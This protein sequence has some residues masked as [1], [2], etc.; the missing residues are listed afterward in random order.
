MEILIN[1]IQNRKKII[2][3]VLIVI[4]IIILFAMQFFSKNNIDK[5]TLNNPQSSNSSTPD[6]SPYPTIHK[7]IEPRLNYPIK[8]GSITV[9]FMPKSGTFLIYYLGSA[10]SAK[11]T[12]FEY[13]N[14]LG[15]N[16]GDYRQEY[17]PLDHE[18]IKHSYINN[19]N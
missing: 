7:V 3:V 14:S 18:E 8:Y 11:M 6:Y 2:I 10:R 1:F 13:M 5:D 19:P 15:L 12:Y 4:L 17:F 9:E 16:P